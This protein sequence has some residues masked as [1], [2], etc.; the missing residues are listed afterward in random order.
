MLQKEF[1]VT[2]AWG[3]LQM[4]R[5]ISLLFSVYKIHCDVPGRSRP[6]RPDVAR[7]RHS[8]LTRKPSRRLHLLE[9]NNYCWN[10]RNSLVNAWFNSHINTFK[11]Q[12]TTQCGYA[13]EVNASRTSLDITRRFSVSLGRASLLRRRM[14][15]EFKYNKGPGSWIWGGVLTIDMPGWNISLSGTIEVAKIKWQ[16]THNDIG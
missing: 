10:V 5:K 15:W 16:S 3:G 9:S 13:R 11:A 1:Q 2:E 8:I 7:C 14:L 4:F 6:I 12:R